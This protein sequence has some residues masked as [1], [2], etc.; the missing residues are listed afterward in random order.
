MNCERCILGREGGKKMGNKLFR[1]PELYEP[2]ML[3][4][5]PGIGNI[6]LIAVNVLKDILKAEELGE[7]E[8]WDFFYPKKVLISNGLLRDL[9]SVE[10]SLWSPTPAQEGY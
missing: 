8:S 4:G 9:P 5:W 2:I 10:R 3:A 7:I 6:G 1:E